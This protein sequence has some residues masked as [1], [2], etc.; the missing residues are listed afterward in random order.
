[1]SG[2]GIVTLFFKIVSASFSSSAALALQGVCF[3]RAAPRVR[4]VVSFRFRKVLSDASIN[5]HRKTQG[6]SA[7]LRNREANLGNGASVGWDVEFHFESIKFCTE[8]EVLKVISSTI[9]I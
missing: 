8:G 2:G 7:S 5:M 4:L 6:K 1:M 9:T 3:V